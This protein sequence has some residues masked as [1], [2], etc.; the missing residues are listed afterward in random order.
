MRLRRPAPHHDKPRSLK[1]LDEPLGR[2]PRHELVGV[3][4]SLAA[5]EA[6]L[7]GEGLLKIIGRGWHHAFIVGHARTVSDR[8]ERIK[9]TIRRPGHLDPFLLAAKI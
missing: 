7:E 1:V 2:H 5:V 4:H 8:A 3:V 6:Q 9:K